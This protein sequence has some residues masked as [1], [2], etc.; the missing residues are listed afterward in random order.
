M[1]IGEG[2]ASHGPEARM[3]AYRP[4]TASWYPA[5]RAL[6]DVSGAEPAGRLGNDTPAPKWTRTRP[7]REAQKTFDRVRRPL[8][9][10]D[11]H[12]TRRPPCAT[13]DANELPDAPPREYTGTYTVTGL[14]LHLKT[15][16]SRARR[17]RTCV[18]QPFAATLF[19]SRAVDSDIYYYSYVTTLALVCWTNIPHAYL[20]PI[21]L[22]ARIRR[23]VSPHEISGASAAAISPEKVNTDKIDE[24]LRKARG[25]VPAAVVGASMVHGQRNREEAA[26][27]GRTSG[28]GRADVPCTEDN[29]RKQT[30]RMSGAVCLRAGIYIC[31]HCRTP[32]APRISTGSREFGCSYVSKCQCPDLGPPRALPLTVRTFASP[33]LAVGFV[34]Q[35][36]LIRG[37]G[38]R[39][40]SSRR[41]YT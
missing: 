12:L 9:R 28:H 41:D 39:R 29:N 32:R 31:T 22:C 19:S 18:P 27:E 4:R 15:V 34:V 33:R 26:A 35:L 38:H 20:A 7:R 2:V 5:A 37:L 16:L 30:G 24:K 17:P 23:S 10:L 13:H 11:H 8:C 25:D 14:R 40:T 36:C 6:Q 3:C 1:T 21:W